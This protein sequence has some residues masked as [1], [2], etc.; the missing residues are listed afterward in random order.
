ML[1]ELE[2]LEELEEDENENEEEIDWLGLKV[3]KELPPQKMGDIPTKKTLVNLKKLPSI[4]DEV[5]GVHRKK[6][7]VPE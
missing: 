1:K 6:F 3:K 2:E 4:D 7:E 5:V